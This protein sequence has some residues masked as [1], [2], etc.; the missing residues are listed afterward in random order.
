MLLFH[1]PPLNLLI[2]SLNLYSNYSCLHYYCWSSSRQIVC[3]FS[4]SFSSSFL[5]RHHLYLPL[6]PLLFH[7]LHLVVFD[8]VFVA[9]FLFDL[10]AKIG[11]I[12]IFESFISEFDIDFLNDMIWVP[13]HHQQFVL[14]H[15]QHLLQ[16][17]VLTVVLYLE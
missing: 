9:I 5:F 11:R 8:V 15:H 3:A 7:H 16:P 4:F 14:H 10:H 2:P 6:L 13:D 17:Q 1:P 12:Y